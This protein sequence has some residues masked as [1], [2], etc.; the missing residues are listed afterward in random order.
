MGQNKMMASEAQDLPEL[1]SKQ[2]AILLDAQMHL[3]CLEFSAANA[4]SE[5]FSHSRSVL[6]SAGDLSGLE[7]D[8]K[9]AL[10]ALILGLHLRV[11]ED[12]KLA[13]SGLLDQADEF[14]RSAAQYD[15]EPLIEAA[16]LHLLAMLQT[17]MRMQH[18]ALSQLS[19]ALEL[20]SGAGEDVLANGI[21]ATRA[22]VM[23]QGEMYEDLLS[24]GGAN[25]QQAQADAA[26]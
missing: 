1:Q 5:T 22:A 2:R 13:D 14:A 8:P 15:D 7:H 17:R 19:P 6:A 21:Q 9:N 3:T 12:N 4:A 18:G 20:T 25:A 24:L 11:W 10:F 26:R 16:A 23:A